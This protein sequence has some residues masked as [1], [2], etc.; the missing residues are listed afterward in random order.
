MV[1][2]TLKL[3]IAI[4]NGGNSTVQQVMSLSKLH[5]VLFEQMSP[6]KFVS[7][8][9]FHSTQREHDREKVI[10]WSSYK[11]TH[12]TGLKYPQM[13]ALTNEFIYWEMNL[14]LTIFT[15]NYGGMVASIVWVNSQ[16]FTL[17]WSNSDMHS[18]ETIL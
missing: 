8:S 1:V 2:A 15:S 5:N 6:I 10:M 12:K 18:V 13:L 9:V 4:L 11:P 16:F 3:G 14:S 7:M 17:C